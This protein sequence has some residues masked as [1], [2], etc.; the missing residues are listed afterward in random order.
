MQALLIRYGYRMIFPASFFEWQLST[1]VCWFLIW[2]WYFTLWIVFVLILLADIA[3]DTMYYRIG[4]RSMT[5]NKVSTFIDKSNFLS[6]HLH[7]MKGVWFLVKTPI[8][9]ALLSLPVQEWLICRFLVFFPIVY[10]PLLFNQLFYCLL[11]IIYEIDIPLRVS[12]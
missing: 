11:A 2:K 1:L 12:I 3:C 10:P 7:T 4:R 5:S 9:L 6:G 8:W